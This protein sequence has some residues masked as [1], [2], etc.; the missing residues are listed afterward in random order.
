M[1]EPITERVHVI[2][3]LYHILGR[4]IMTLIDKE[5]EPREHQM[6]FDRTKISSGVY[7][8]WFQVVLERHG[9]LALSEIYKSVEK[10]R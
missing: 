8:C 9:D 2:V 10:N 6:V 4:E 1:L 5:K 7:L 3:K